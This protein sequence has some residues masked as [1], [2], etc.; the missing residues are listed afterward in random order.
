MSVPNPFATDQKITDFLRAHAFTLSA[1]VIPPRNGAEYTSI[2]NQIHALIGAGAQF[3]SVTKGAG[4]SL[5][6]GSLPI[7]QAIK[8]RF[9]VPVIAHF[10][11][12]DLTPAEVENSLIDHH[13]FGVRNILALR[14]D[15]P[16]GQQWSAREGSYSYAYELIGQIRALNQGQYLGRAGGGPALTSPSQATD[17][18]IGAAA[19]PEHPVAEERARFFALKVQAGAEY[20]ITDMLFNADFYAR[21]R[22]EITAAGAA[23]PVLPGTR[24]LKTRKAARRIAERFRVTVPESVLRILPEDE[25]S[26]S[27]ESQ[28]SAGLEAFHI[29]VEQLRRAGAPGVHLYVI[30]DTAAASRGLQSLSSQQS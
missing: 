2:L 14:G 7:A 23:V 10:T 22:D 21:F 18:C 28:L 5:R 24:I 17:F 20:G 3:L 26:A 9:Q 12:R 15:P 8:D 6:G 4:G 13:Y 25:N 11:C 1:E 29:L 27:A 16:V 30:T 19:Y